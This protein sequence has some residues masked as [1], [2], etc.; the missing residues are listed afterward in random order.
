MIISRLAPSPTGYLHLGNAFSF[1][2][3]WLFVRK[4][5]GRI[6]LRMDDI[7]PDRSKKEFSRA[8]IEDLLWLGL[9]WDEGPIPQSGNSQYYRVA[10]E[11][12]QSQDLVY[13]CFCA[14]KDLRSLASAPQIGYMGVP[15]PGTCASLSFE[16]ANRRIANGAAACHR[17][18]VP[19][20]DV[21]FEDIVYGSN[22]FSP[23]DFGGDFALIRSDGVFAYQLASVVDDARMGVNL[24]MRGRDLLPSTPRQIILF[25]MLG[26]ET[27][28]F[29]H[30][31]LLLD[32]NGERLAKRHKSLALRALRQNNVP[33]AN[34]VGGLANLAGITPKLSPAMPNDL[35][36]KLD[37]SLLPKNDIRLPTSFTNMLESKEKIF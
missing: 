20:E 14:R 2:L 10:L 1:L 33:A 35:I 5:G 37:L 3:N 22:S 4:T 9:D 11:R 24:I 18:R 23:P 26:F 21:K 13:P 12:L 27:P 31:P 36:D 8:V 34:I 17:L 19:A 25:K 32:E 29:A 16:E 15:Y 6:I 30:L 7:D 28:N